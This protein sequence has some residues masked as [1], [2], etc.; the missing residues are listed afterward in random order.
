MKNV[1]Q[2]TLAASARCTKSFLKS[3]YERQ[4]P[5]NVES[6]RVRDI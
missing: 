1:N 5:I 3:V 4:Q 2:I 6:V